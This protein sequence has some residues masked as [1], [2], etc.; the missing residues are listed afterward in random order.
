LRNEETNLK[1]GKR[2]AIKCPGVASDVIPV[3]AK[4][5]AAWDKAAQAAHAKLVKWAR[6]QTCEPANAKCPNGCARGFYVITQED[7]SLP[8]KI[9]GR[10]TATVHCY[11]RED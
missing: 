10:V 4:N 2:M 1:E 5:P 7:P 11:C 6:E 8:G 9:T 3:V